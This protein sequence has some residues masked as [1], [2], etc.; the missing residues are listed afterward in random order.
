MFEL[1]LTLFNLLEAIA[2][3]KD[4]A[5]F[6]AKEAQAE[7]TARKRNKPAPTAEDML[8]FLILLGII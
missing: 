3:R 6:A 7:K 1:L 4:L 5:A 8:R 2:P